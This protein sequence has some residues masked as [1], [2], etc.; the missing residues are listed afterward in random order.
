M[1]SV[2]NLGRSEYSVVWLP[3]EPSVD[4]I[5]PPPDNR[6]NDRVASDEALPGMRDP[7]ARARFLV[8]FCIGVIATLAW[9]S[10]SDA[11]RQLVETS[12]LQFGGLVPIAQTT[13]DVIAP[14]TFAGP[15]LDEQHLAAVHQNVD[16]RAAGQWQINPTVVQLASAQ[17]QITRDFASL[18]QQTERHT[19][20]KMSVPLPR[21]APAEMRKHASRPAT[22][23]AGTGPNAHH[24]GISSTRVGSSSPLPVLSTGLDTGHKRTRS[25]AAALKSSAP[26]PFSQSLMYASQSLK[27]ALSKITGIQL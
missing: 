3:T 4:A 1:G 25:S 20:S 21:Q 18:Q 6:K 13:P 15:A 11:A 19:I 27:S 26:E 9:Q 17:V 10:C 14:A 5:M 24:A 16:R 7:R 2:L 12:S 8:A 23:T 22:A